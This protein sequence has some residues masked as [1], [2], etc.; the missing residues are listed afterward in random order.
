ME[1]VLFHGSDKIVDNPT[2]AGGRLHNDFGQGFYCTPDIQLAREWSC[3]EAPSAFV[4]HYSFEPSYDLKICNLSGKEFNILNWLAVLMSNR[5]FETS[6]SIPAAVK[7]YIIEQFLPD[8]SSFDIIR[9]YRADDSYFQYTNLFLNG[10][11]S[12]E[13]LNEAMHLGHLGEQVFIQSEKA[14]EALVFTSAEVVDKPFY[15]PQRLVRERRARE[16]FQKMKHGPSA[17]D[18]IFAIDVYRNKMKNDDLRLR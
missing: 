8:L 13:Q 2:R 18:G 10:T 1:S 6:Q 17:M 7:G 3:T 15:F 5:V 12:L 4:N 14:F 11:I 9:G 16:A